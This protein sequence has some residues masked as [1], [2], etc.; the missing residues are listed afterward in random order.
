MF[1]DP[2]ILE[3]K[4]PAKACLIWL[5][6]LGA[7]G[8]DFEPVIPEL[9]LPVDLPLR[10]I[11]PHAPIRPVTINAGYAMPAWYDILEMNLERKID[12]AELQESADYVQ[13]LIDD[14]IQQGIHS[15]HIFLAGFSQGGAVA[16]QA[17]LSYPHPLGGLLAL[18]TYFASA[19]QQ[20]FH[21]ANQALNI[22]IQHGLQDD[23][24]PEQLGQKA[25][26]VLQAQ[27][28]TPEY[29]TYAMEHSLCL[30]QVKAIGHWLMKKLDS[31]T[32]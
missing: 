18:S 13:R 26:S 3:P 16:Y 6:G 12:L 23:V 21:P 31:C 10:C 20:A 11:F 9:G 25:L 24:V 30:A 8:Y 2:L 5:H 15:E 29:Q 27:G 28:L 32:P 4:T 7:D 22:L 1:A 17:A 19:E 14:Q